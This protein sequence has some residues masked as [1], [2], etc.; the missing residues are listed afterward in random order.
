MS[1]YPDHPSQSYHLMTAGS[2]SRETSDDRKGFHAIPLTPSDT[3]IDDSVKSGNL[4][5]YLKHKPPRLA[6]SDSDH[7]SPPP[8]HYHHHLQPRT[9][10]S[11]ESEGGS[12]RFQPPITMFTAGF[13]PYFMTHQHSVS[14]PS[15][16]LQQMMSSPR[17][18]SPPPILPHTVSGESILGSPISR[19]YEDRLYPPLEPPQSLSS[20]SPTT[21]LYHSPSPC[22]EMFGAKSRMMGHH[23]SNVH[24]SPSFH[25]PVPYGSSS[26]SV[27]SNNPSGLLLPK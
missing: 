13:S 5:K 14:Q 8:P 12:A 11:G 3:S 23:S 24:Q 27:F 22:L 25:P 4:I 20:I 15:Q 16:A 18:S 26:G 21:G 6:T 9:S 19:Q 7:T 17:Y 10:A 2:V 1:G